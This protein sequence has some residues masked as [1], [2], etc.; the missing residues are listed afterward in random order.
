M[1]YRPNRIV[2]MRK[3]LSLPTG[4]VG[5][6]GIWPG[7]VEYRPGVEGTGEVG[8]EGGGMVI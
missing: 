5:L 7:V 2:R 3:G 6:C 1:S 8:I 4:V